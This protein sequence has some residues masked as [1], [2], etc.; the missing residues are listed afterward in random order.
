MLCTEP[1]IRLSSSHGIGSPGRL[2]LPNFS[3]GLPHCIPVENLQ[4]DMPGMGPSECQVWALLLSCGPFPMSVTNA[5]T[6]LLR[7]FNCMYRGLNQRV[8]GPFLPN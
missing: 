6:F 5:I 8:L 7:A 3:G 1:L 4:L 2:Q